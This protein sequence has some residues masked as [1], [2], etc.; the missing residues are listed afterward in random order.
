[1]RFALCSKALV[2]GWS[3]A[4]AAAREHSRACTDSGE[5]QDSGRV[6]PTFRPIAALPCFTASCA[7]ST[8]WILP[9][10]LHVV[11]SWSY[12]RRAPVLKNTPGKSVTQACTLVLPAC[13]AQV[14]V[15]RHHSSP[16]TA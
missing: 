6:P 15:G 10:G 5:K 12:C 16:S 3:A 9:C 13:D 4:A 1:M 7:Y 2:S 11:T 14:R 8:W